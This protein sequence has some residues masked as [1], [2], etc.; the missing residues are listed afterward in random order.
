M[1]MLHAIA[2][3]LK[4][5]DILADDV[6]NKEADLVKHFTHVKLCFLLAKT[7]EDN[8]HAYFCFLICCIRSGF[9]L[10]FS[11]MYCMSQIKVLADGFTRTITNLVIPLQTGGILFH[12]TPS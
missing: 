6:K 11:L 8:T 4:K 9:D 12:S 3:H 2:S 5:I 1:E 10:N 7:G